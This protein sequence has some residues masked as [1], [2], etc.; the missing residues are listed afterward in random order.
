V[1]VEMAETTRIKEES[2]DAGDDARVIWDSPV[3]FFFT[4]FLLWETFGG[5]CTRVSKMGEV[6]VQ[7]TWLDKRSLPC[8]PTMCVLLYRILMHYMPMGQ[9][10]SYY[11]VALDYPLIGSEWCPHI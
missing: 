6:S 11:T 5:F 2:L 4:F 8:T 7:H 1:K 3:Q 10:Y 9:G